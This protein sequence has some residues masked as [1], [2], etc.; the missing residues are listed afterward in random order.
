MKR[1]GL[2]SLHSNRPYKD[3]IPVGL[4]IPYQGGDAAPAGWDLFESANGKWIIGA[5]DTYDVGDNSAVNA[6]I[7]WTT[8]DG[9]SHTGSTFY[10]YSDGGIGGN[11]GADS[12]GAKTGGT[13]TVTVEDYD[14][15]YEQLVLIKS[16]LGNVFY[17]QDGIVLGAQDFGG[18]AVVKD[19][20][21]LLKA[22]TTMASGAAQT[23]DSVTSGT[24]GNHDHRVTGAKRTLSNGHTVY[25]YIAAGAHSHTVGIALTQ[26]TKRFY[27]SAW[28][29]AAANFKN[30]SGMI[31]MYESTTPP[32]GW[33]LCDGDSG[34]PDLTDHFIQLD[35][36][37]N[38]NQS[39]G[40]NTV[41]GTESSISSSG[42]H[43]HQGESHGG[44]LNRR[45]V[46]HIATA[47]A[48]TNHTFDADKSWLPPYYALA[49]IMRG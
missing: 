20:A 15:G 40:D 41:N 4:I 11:D 1:Y 22:G 46:H 28:T 12:S 43:T 39:A 14:P 48:H 30:A 16:Q 42:G 37:A 29:D 35:S 26:Q 24:S 45:A 47:G 17:P 6:D 38:D 36:A 32:P 7:V 8:S 2:Y 3:N 5:G 19:T 33:I 18:L 10:G 9:G 27:L 25:D 34:T 21:R 31:A 23:V 13:H 49:F 44:L